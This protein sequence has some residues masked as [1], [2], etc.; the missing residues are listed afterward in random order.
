[1]NAKNGARPAD[2]PSGGSGDPPR[3]T[4]YIEP[5]I[6]EYLT[7]RPSPDPLT[8]SE[9]DIVG[10]WWEKTAVRFDLLAPR[11][12][13]AMAEGGDPDTSRLRLRALEGVKLVDPAPEADRLRD[14]L[15]QAHLIP[16]Y[17]A[18]DA[19][20]FALA[21]VHRADILVVMNIQYIGSALNR[22]QIEQ[23]SRNLGHEPP[24]PYPP[25]ELLGGDYPDAEDIAELR[26]IR[27]ELAA[28]YNPDIRAM[29]EDIQ[30]LG[31]EGCLERTYRALGL[32]PPSEAEVNVG[33]ASGN[34]RSP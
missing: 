9:Q 8:A 10:T 19:A 13:L 31:P 30:R 1:M 3:E 25:L 4:A 22:P 23:V 14:A 5:A 15:L 29:R 11:S 16:P 6:V 33:P 2:A 18:S 26:Q 28:E 21:A 32:A 7:A 34:G 17:A 27:K 12:V 20:H 24:R